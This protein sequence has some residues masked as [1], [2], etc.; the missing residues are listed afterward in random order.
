[1]TSCAEKESGP[2]GMAARGAHRTF[3]GSFF[4]CKQ[5]PASL[6]CGRISSPGGSNES[7]GSNRVPQGSV[8]HPGNQERPGR[9]E[10]PARETGAVGWCC[11]SDRK[12]NRSGVAE[13]Y[14]GQGGG[15]E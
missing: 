8:F 11:G 7:G 4:D 15:G 9:S 3:L 1:M 2:R 12:A 14:F 6:A 5:I 13:R 10:I